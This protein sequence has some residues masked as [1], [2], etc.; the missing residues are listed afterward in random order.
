MVKFNPAIYCHKVEQ[1]INDNRP[2]IVMFKSRVITKI[3]QEIGQTL[4]SYTFHDLQFDRGDINV[5]FNLDIIEDIMNNYK[6]LC[7]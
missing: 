1:L 4:N 5:G 3:E 6:F 7:I 2:K